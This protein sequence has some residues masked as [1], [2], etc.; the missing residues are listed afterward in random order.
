MPTID[1]TLLVDVPYYCVRK[2]SSPEDEAS[3]RIV[4]SGQMPL[5]SILDLS[6]NENVREFL[7]DAEGLKRRKPTQVHRAIK[8]TLENRPEMF[9]VLNGGVVIVARISENNE[10]TKT[11]RLLKPSIING[12]QT[13]GVVKGFLDGREEDQDS[14]SVHVKFELIITSDDGLIAEISI[15]R[16]SQDDVQPISIIGRR[17]QL[18]ELNERIRQQ[19]P[20]KR[21]RRSETQRPSDMNDIIDT[22]RLLKVIAALLPKTL[23]WKSG[24][25]SKAYTYD[26]PTTCLKDFALI[27]MR[28]KDP[29]DAQ[30][31]LSKK[32]YEFYL[33]I[34][35]KALKIYEKW[36]RHQGF[37]GTGIHSLKRDDDRRTI[38]EVP[39]GILFPIFAALSEFAVK[40][41]DGWDIVI[42]PQLSDGK[43]IQA[44]K[45]C[46]IDIARSKPDAMGKTKA[47]YMHMQ[48]IT[49]I[50]R[51]LLPQNS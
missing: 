49:S 8:D 4:Y 48:Q 17:G 6:T 7:Q 25:F 34:A 13:Q 2:I 40:G 10:K 44:A 19:Q 21:L 18:D 15:A 33:D 14:L 41:Q 1:S 51:E 43:L 24:E 45:S 50:Y 31:K 29:S 9:S 23:Q 35:P 28:A 12:S 5:R 42:P 27:E 30:H 36:K 47:C 32:V 3:D 26:R 16:N 20:K 38:L 37:Q 46:Y 22:E 11:L 39:D